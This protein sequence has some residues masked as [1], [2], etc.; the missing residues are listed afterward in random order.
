VLNRA[1]DNLIAK[2]GPDHATLSSPH[3]E[4]LP[5][6]HVEEDQTAPGK[7]EEKLKQPTRSK[8]QE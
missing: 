1:I 6:P 3:R 2:V 8:V 4:K 5:S 7:R